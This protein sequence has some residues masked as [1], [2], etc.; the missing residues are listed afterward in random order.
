MGLVRDALLGQSPE[1]SGLDPGAYQG[2]TGEAGAMNY[3]YQFNE[4]VWAYWAEIIDR[5]EANSL[6]H[7]FGTYY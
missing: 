6:A 3:G 2:N 5:T 4:H 7:V 1:G